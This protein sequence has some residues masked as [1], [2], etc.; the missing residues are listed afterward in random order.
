MPPLP[1]EHSY[2]DK[3]VYRVQGFTC[4][5]CA[6]IFEKTSRIFPA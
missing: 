2:I 1:N 6:G 5:R 4:T 3:Q